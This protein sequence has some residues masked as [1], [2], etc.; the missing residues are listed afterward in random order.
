MRSI[1]ILSTLLA[2]SLVG[3]Y[4]TW[5]APEKKGSADEIAMYAAAEGEVSAV[6]WQTEKLTVLLERKEDAGGPYTWVTVT[7]RK[8]VR[9]PLPPPPAEGEEAP[10]EPEPTIEETTLSFL[11]NTAA[12][13]LL[14]SFT[15]LHA[16]RE[17]AVSDPKSAA[18]GLDQ[19]QGQ[20]E[21]TRRSGPLSFDLGGETYGTKDRYVRQGDK[22]WLVAANTLRPLQNAKARLFESALQPNTAEQAEQVRLQ[23]GGTAYAWTHQNRADKAQAF[24]SKAEDPKA[25]DDAGSAVVDKLL[26]LRAQQYLAEGAAPAGLAP[27]YT[28]AVNGDKGA[29]QVEIARD[30]ASSEWYARS[31]YTRGWV[32]LT[33]SM[34]TELEQAISDLASGGGAEPAEPSAPAEPAAP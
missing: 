20:V 9:P 17:L 4:L 1:V 13:D 15:P 22:V 3:S 8:E 27:V 25:A 30:A 18:F 14:G 34:A 11:G 2:V 33:K 31:G 26:R 5:T 16:L 23:V 19:P 32:M 10:P 12:T 29:W 21:V 7:E 6:R 24:W 28:A